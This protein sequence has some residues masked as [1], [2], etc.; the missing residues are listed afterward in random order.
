MGVCL[1]PASRTVHL[2]V[3]LASF[4]LLT[5]RRNG[6]VTLYDVSRGSDGLLHCN[7]IPACLPHDG[8]MFTAYDGHALVA[9][10]SDMGLA[11]LRLCQR[12]SIRRQDIRVARP[13]EDQP[14]SVQEGHVTHQWDED[15]QTL[16]KQVSELHID[17]GPAAGRHF[18][19][20]NLRGTYEGSS[21]HPYNNICSHDQC[22][23]IC[24]YSQ[25]SRGH[26]SGR[27][28]RHASSI[29]RR[30]AGHRGNY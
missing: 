14:G 10:P 7:S 26:A 24:N 19:E 2:S 28:Q 30:L 23:D 5:S 29:T 3:S 12:G 13:D 1:F 8:P 18:T 11:F 17:F 21:F 25:Y 15:V 22:R 20:V 4:S 9:L 16:E 6:F 27:V